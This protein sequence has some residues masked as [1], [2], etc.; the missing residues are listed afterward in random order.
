[1]STFGVLFEFA[2]LYECLNFEDSV[3]INIAM[4]QLST[5]LVWDCGNIW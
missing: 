1:M 5:M 2:R 3:H 4:P